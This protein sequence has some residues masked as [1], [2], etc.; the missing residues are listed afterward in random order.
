MIA[1][2]LKKLNIVL[3][4]A[5][6]P[7]GA[8][9]AYKIINYLSDIELPIESG[10]FKLIS[11]MAVE[12]ILKMNE[13]DPY[14]RGLSVWVGFNQSF[15]YY[16]RQPRAQGVPKFNFFSKNPYLEFLRAIT[17]FSSKPLYFGVFIGI[18]TIL[19]SLI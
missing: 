13:K 18:I 8:Y 5:P 9:V 16:V 7:V 14:I 3:P 2:N 4:N 12:H 19:I 1:D 17:S 6:D 10:D 15:Y 11:K